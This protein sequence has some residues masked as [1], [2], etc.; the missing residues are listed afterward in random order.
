MGT[1]RRT[2]R[3][4]YMPPRHARKNRLMVHVDRETGKK[5]NINSRSVLVRKGD[6]V[7]VARGA[8]RGKSGQVLAV[9]YAKGTIDLEGITKTNSRSK[10]EVAVA[11]QPSNVLLVSRGDIKAIAKRVKKK[12]EP[13]EEKK[14]EANEKKAEGRQPARMDA[15]NEKK[16]EGRQPARM[17]A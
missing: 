15:S 17:E 3:A 8:Y 16:A 13:K 7:K 9:N 10:K 14:E 1:I 11:I 5:L 12:A 2:R 4:F 6:T